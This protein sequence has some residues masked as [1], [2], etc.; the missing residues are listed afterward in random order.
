MGRFRAGMLRGGVWGKSCLRPT[1][2]FAPDHPGEHILGILVPP[3]AGK[4]VSLLPFDS[5]GASKG[6]QS[7]RVPS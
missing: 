5:L 2:N 3:A 6:V 4:N 7:Q 1:E